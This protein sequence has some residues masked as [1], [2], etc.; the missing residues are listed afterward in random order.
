MTE[1]LFHIASAVAWRESGDFYAPAEFEKEGFVH[2]ATRSQ[3]FG[4]AGARFAGHSD[5][6]LLMIDANHIDAP[7]RYENLGGGAELFPHVYSALP[8]S[9]V[10]AVEPLVLLS[11]GSFEPSVVQRCIARAS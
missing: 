6:V 11:D 8:R 3:V 7:I 1:P 5:L 10:V 4:V 9:S 2:C